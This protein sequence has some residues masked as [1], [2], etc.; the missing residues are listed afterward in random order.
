MNPDPAQHRVRRAVRVRGVVQG[1]GFRPFVYRLASQLA[2]S[3]HIGNDTDGVTIHIEGSSESV[4]AFLHRLRSE[5]PPISRIDSVAVEEL[6]PTGQ[7]GFTIV[8][9]QVLGAVSTGI[10]ADAATCAD[11]LREL[12]DP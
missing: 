5:A 10:P 6:P 12:F 4:A 3:G 9:S 8:H 11:C 7:S 2:L 1:V